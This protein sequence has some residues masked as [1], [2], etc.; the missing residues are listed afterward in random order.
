MK[1]H[2]IAECSLGAFCNTFDLYLSDNR[3]WKPIFVFF[4]SGRLI[5]VLQYFIFNFSS[6]VKSGAAGDRG[7]DTNADQ[8][9]VSEQQ[10]GSALGPDWTSDLHL[11]GVEKVWVGTQSKR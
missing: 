6:D 7:S 2:S 4:L 11:R 8:A 10:A 9:D 1:V 5:Q 3:S